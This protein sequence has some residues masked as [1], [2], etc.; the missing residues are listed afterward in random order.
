MSTCIAVIPLCVP[1]TL[2]SIS[3]KKSSIPWISVSIIYL[4]GSSGLVTS[5][6]EIPAT[7]AVIGTP[8]SIR[9]K[10]LPQILPWDVDPFELSTSETTLI[11]YGKSSSEG[12]TGIKAFSAS[13]PCP[14]SRLPG[15]RDV[16]ASPTLYEGKLYWC[17]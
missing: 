3:P 8:A 2:K 10:V 16:L 9:A 6:V 12:K 13:A 1:P 7:G 14:I 4:S 11:A 5:P 17:I 15:P